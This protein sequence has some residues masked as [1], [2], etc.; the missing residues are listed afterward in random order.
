[1]NGVVVEAVGGVAA[2]VDDPS[3]GEE[4]CYVQLSDYHSER[5]D[6]SVGTGV[7]SM[8]YAG[9][10][11]RGGAGEGFETDLCWCTAKAGGG[12]EYQP[13]ILCYHLTATNPPQAGQGISRNFIRI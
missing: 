8:C 4:E 3:D 11:S 5:E 6:L 12:W 1:M 9:K 7:A 2:S 10:L 13:P